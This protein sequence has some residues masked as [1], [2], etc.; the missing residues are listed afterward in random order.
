MC[1]LFIS[2][3]AFGSSVIKIHDQ[4]SCFLNTGRSQKKWIKCF[5]FTLSKAIGRE[6]FS[7]GAEE[8]EEDE[9]ADA[10][11][12]GCEATEPTEVVDENCGR[13]V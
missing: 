11:C 8:A 10:A 12:D 13:S 7:I 2:L 9:E 6:S 4:L 5:P 1:V 3:E